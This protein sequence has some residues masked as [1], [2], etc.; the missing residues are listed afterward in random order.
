MSRGYVQTFFQ[1][2][3]T[4]S[5]QTHEMMFNITNYQGNANQKY[6][7]I[8]PYTSQNGYNYQEKNKCWRGCGEKGTLIHYWWE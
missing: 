2:R 5:Q 8:S 6:T 3:C 1:R 7:E 4:D